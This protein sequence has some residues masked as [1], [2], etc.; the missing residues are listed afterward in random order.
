MS[1]Q[2]TTPLKFLSRIVPKKLVLIYRIGLDSLVANRKTRCGRDMVAVAVLEN[3][4]SD[5]TSDSVT[6]EEPDQVSLVVDCRES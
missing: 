5:S 1:S 4:K 6:V 2:Q 3:H